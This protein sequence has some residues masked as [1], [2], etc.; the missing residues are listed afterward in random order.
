MVVQIPTYHIVSKV[1]APPKGPLKL[2]TIIDSLEELNPLNAGAEPTID[3][4][5]QFSFHEEEFEITREQ[6][7]KGTG[8]V[9]IKFVAV[10]GVGVDTS[11]G[12][13]TTINDTYKFAELD[14]KY[15][16]PCISDYEAAVVAKGVQRH[17]KYSGYKPVY[18]ITGMKIGHRP[19][20]TLKRNGVVHGTFS[21]GVDTATVT[22]GPHADL[23]KTKNITQAAKR[24]PDSIV[25]GI[26]VRKLSYKRKY[27]IVGDRELEDDSYN[28]EAELVG[29][30]RDDD[31]GAE[32]APQFDVSE[33]KFDKEL[34]GL[35]LEERDDANEGK[36]AFVH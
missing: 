26:R 1:P 17:L 28:D 6:I 34:D 33:L 35:V 2:G 16:P 30:D 8:G 20:V 7:V 23:S 19:E 11:A 31:T 36:I 32:K 24:S 15:F 3:E 25:F 9:G 14:T 27:I 10:P 12:G 13:E 21:I 29:V 22:V 4:S 5:R 18:M